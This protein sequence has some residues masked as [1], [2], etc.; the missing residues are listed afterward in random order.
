MPLWKPSKFLSERQKNWDGKKKKLLMEEKSEEGKTRS[1][2]SP[3]AAE[4]V[5]TNVAAV[6]VFIDGTHTHTIGHLTRSA[7]A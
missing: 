3:P 7:S 5:Q 2:W 6:A 4:S 1:G